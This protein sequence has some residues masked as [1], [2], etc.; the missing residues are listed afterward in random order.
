MINTLF[1][2]NYKPNLPLSKKTSFSNK[3]FRLDRDTVTFS[4]QP[5]Q[6]SPKTQLS[7]TGLTQTLS[8]K[9]FNTNN[10]IK[11]LIEKEEHQN[12]P[13]RG[14]VGNLPNNWMAKLSKDNKE[15]DIKQIYTAF[16]DAA[17]LI[18][19]KF[20][21][22]ESLG[23]KN[24]DL[25]R[26]EPQLTE[27]RNII[28][29]SLKDHGLV[30]DTTELGF[31]HVGQGRYG[32]T[33]KFKVEDKLFIYKVFFTNAKQTSSE[34]SH[35]ILKE[36]NRAAFIKKHVG[37]CQY[38]ELFFADMKSGYMITRL[39]NND[40]KT[41]LFID[42]TS[43]GAKNG[44]VNEDGP[45][46]GKYVD[47]NVING[48]VVDY[49]GI[50]IDNHL[51]ATNKTIRWVYKQFKDLPELEQ[52]LE[53][54]DELYKTVINNK[55]PN[56]HDIMT[57]LIDYAKFLPREKQF[58]LADMMI[59]DE[60]LSEELVLKLK[61]YIIEKDNFSRYQFSEMERTNYYL[62]LFNR[63]SEP[64]QKELLKE[65]TNLSGFYIKEIFSA[66][67]SQLDEPTK[68]MLAESVRYQFRYEAQW[69]EAVKALYP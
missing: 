12:S 37:P 6:S 18:N 25:P 4:Q 49:G 56:C 52:K 26:L 50:R 69:Q 29:E 48:Y 42:E 13:F 53:K 41:P 7:F 33:F 14:I 3:Q 64:A 23:F 65:I 36:V 21:E 28:T 57:G 16:A 43:Y 38:P 20:K 35:G 58:I 15:S 2:Q 45:N 55:V 32:I 17:N 51:L 59:A 34:L 30:K 60:N 11:Q 54:W 27:A 31:E 24:E 44:D 66:L 47:Q 9:L 40:S 1:L 39:I 46:K 61:P 62:K 68:N 67:A 10:D 63:F 5:I 19:A 8:A 22:V